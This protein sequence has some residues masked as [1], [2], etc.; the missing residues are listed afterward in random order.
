[1]RLALV[2]V[3]LGC[4]S[5]TYNVQLWQQLAVNTSYKSVSLRWT[6]WTST[7]LSS[8]GISVRSKCL[9]AAAGTA[10]CITVTTE[11]TVLLHA[12]ASGGRGE[13]WKR[14]SLPTRE[15]ARKRTVG[16][17]YIYPRKALR[18]FRPVS[19]GA[20]AL[21]LLVDKKPGLF[22]LSARR[23][24]WLATES[25]GAGCA[26]E[27]RQRRFRSSAGKH[28]TSHLSLR[29]REIRRFC[30]NSERE[31][32]SDFSLD[33]RLPLDAWK[34]FAPFSTCAKTRTLLIS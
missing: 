25:L 6:S 9:E 20:G 18:G 21:T 16:Q 15:E 29:C 8:R 12:G 13:D 30:R 11:K 32:A 22:S 3:S 14:W 10:G 17:V 26:R 28:R 4:L 5:S 34:G 33:S 1:M 23:N 7:V 24:L 31:T 2:T 27:T 19:P